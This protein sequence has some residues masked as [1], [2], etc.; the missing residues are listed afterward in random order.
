LDV[1]GNG[2]TPQ[3][4]IELAIVPID[5]GRLADVRQW[6]V[7]PQQPVTDFATRL[8]GITNATLANCPRFL[9]VASAVR[10]TLEGTVLVGHHVGV[11][12][13]LVKAQL[14]GWRPIAVIDT[15]K[16]AKHLRPGADSYAL[17]VL[18]DTLALD[19]TGL[20]RHR[21]A[22]DA[23]LTAKLFLTLASQLD[24]GG[25]LDLRMLATLAAS[26]DDPL[27]QSQQRSFF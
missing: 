20:R 15:L 24:L 23:L 12:F 19:R 14:I 2:S 17:D 9:D 25:A 16:L 7:R 3:E 26:A 1:E 6:L 5:T 13:Q 22:G 10:S 4:I 21:A 27:L 8:H 18:A 11:D